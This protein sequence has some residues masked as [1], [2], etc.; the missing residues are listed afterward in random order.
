MKDGR[1]AV[2]SKV[3]MIAYPDGPI[4]EVTNSALGEEHEAGRE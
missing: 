4:M 3:R 1:P 2:G